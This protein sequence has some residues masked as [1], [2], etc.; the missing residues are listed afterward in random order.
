MNALNAYSSPVSFHSV[1][2]HLETT[3]PDSSGGGKVA[4]NHVFLAL[5]LALSVVL[6]GT[7]GCS[8]K[9]A[10]ASDSG[11]D[12]AVTA[13][14]SPPAT[15]APQPPPTVVANPASP[16]S[17]DGVHGA[18]AI[19]DN[20]DTDTGIVP[21][22][23]GPNGNTGGLPPASPDPNGSFRILCRPGH[24]SRDDPIIYPG[25]PGATHLHQFW[26]NTGTNAASTY[27]SL[28]TTGQ[29]TCADTSKGP[30][31]RTAYW[32]P[33]M[34]DGAGNV[35]KPDLIQN[36]YKREPTTD[37]RCTSRG[38]ICVPFPN[39]LRFI[40]GY[41][42]KSGRGGILDEGTNFYW[43]NRFECW[44]DGT[45]D[46]AVQGHWRTIDAVV[47]AG[48]PAGAKLVIAFVGPNCWDGKNL[49]SPDHRSHLSWATRHEGEGYQCPTSHPY[50]IPNY[51]GHI[52]YT[53]DANFT[54]GKWKLS[55]DEHASHMSG[56]AVAAGSTLHFDYFEAWSPPVKAQW[57][58]GCL[59]MHKSCNRGDL[60]NGKMIAPEPAGARPTHQLV[61]I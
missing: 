30:V 12:V 34:L 25:Q 54:A 24:I 31:N 58:K 28:R 9:S 18:A 4:N 53:T 46:P 35:V 41:D 23:Y 40:F 16:V 5:L 39:G 20:F 13:P 1:P 22:D 37:V 2:D 48:C 59:E 21:T 55:S 36:Y 17:A 52:D 38:N 26:G 29:T 33:A 7:S 11:S 47:K 6:S 45:G 56:A 19:A 51:S 14:G 57:E 44:K 32:L 8:A 15:A 3:R 42:M 50:L 49:D 61:K 10:A 43:M 27:Q 60:G